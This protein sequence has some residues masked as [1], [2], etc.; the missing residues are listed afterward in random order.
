MTQVTI[1]KAQYTTEQ[2]PLVTEVMESHIGRKSCYFVCCSEDGLTFTF[3][4]PE[5][6][7][8]FDYKIHV[9][10]KWMPKELL[11]LSEELKSDKDII[12]A[13]IEID[14]YEREY[15]GCKK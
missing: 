13:A 9:L 6:A 10:D 1:N 2:W 7:R 3:S 11:F 12:K 14:G 5:A 4:T 8:W 15:E